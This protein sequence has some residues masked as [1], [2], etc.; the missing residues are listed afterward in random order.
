MEKPV[1][2]RIMNTVLGA[3]FSP[4]ARAVMIEANLRLDAFPDLFTHDEYH[5]DNNAF[6]GGRRF[7]DQQRSRVR[8]AL[9]QG[10]ALAAWDAFGRLTHAAQD[11]YAHSNYVD[12]WLAC[13]PNGLAPTAAEI[14]PLDEFLAEHPSLRSGK[15]Y[16][17][18]ELLTFL[19]VIKN[20]VIPRM[21]ADSHA[22]MN[23]DSELCG[24]MFEYAYQAALKRT[25]RELND[26][27][28][29][30]SPSL[31]QLFTDVAVPN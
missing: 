15:T 2:V 6:E 12:L 20:W 14:E 7:I 5:F 21:P 30:L 10:N 31:D 8:P 27:R 25:R 19:P 3:A 23:L 17:P 16:M 29:G 13:Q 28:R 24:P 4:R 9:E 1:H 26:V 18:V 11:F 22:R